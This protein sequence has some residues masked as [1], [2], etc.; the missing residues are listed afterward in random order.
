MRGIALRDEEGAVADP[1]LEL[2]ALQYRELCDRI[3]VLRALT[4][5]LDATLARTRAEAAEEVAR[6][7]AE[8]RR[9]AKELDA[10]EIHEGELAREV[11]E[12]KRANRLMKEEALDGSEE[13]CAD[14]RHD[15]GR[16]CRQCGYDWRVGS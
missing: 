5:H 1:P 6:A 2:Q 14:V 8:T 13:W 12:L 7:R 4:E 10:A 3:S 16:H 15:G 9:L 11:A